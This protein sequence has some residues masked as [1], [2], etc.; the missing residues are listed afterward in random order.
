[1]SLNRLKQIPALS[2]CEAPLWLAMPSLARVQLCERLVSLGKPLH[3]IVLWWSEE[4]QGDLNLVPIIP[5]DKYLWYF[6][7]SICA[8]IFRKVSTGDRSY[9][10]RIPAITI[11]N[12]HKRKDVV[13][14]MLKISAA[15]MDFKLSRFGR[16]L[17]KFDRLGNFLFG[18]YNSHTC[19]YTLFSKTGW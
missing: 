8:I 12:G 2:Q 18:D 14:K 1:M 9:V 5:R 11:E 15:C 6:P 3:A 16:L 10:E 17:R 13:K 7:L 4:F 19:Q